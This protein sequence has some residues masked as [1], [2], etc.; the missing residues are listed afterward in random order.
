MNGNHGGFRTPLKQ[1]RGLGSA[2]DGTGH[3]IR[4]RITAFAVLLGLSPPHRLQWASHF[5]VANLL[6]FALMWGWLVEYAATVVMYVRDR[7]R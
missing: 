1:A 3:F 6:V 7:R 5:M 4:Q 2:K